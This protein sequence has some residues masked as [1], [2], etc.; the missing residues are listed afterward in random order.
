M[1]F[2]LADLRWSAERCLE[3]LKRFFVL[4]VF[5]IPRALPIATAPLKWSKA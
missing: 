2:W 5:Q 1:A 4:P 3:G